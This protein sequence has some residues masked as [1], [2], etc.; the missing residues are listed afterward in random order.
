MSK[1]ALLGV[2]SVRNWL[3]ASLVALTFGCATEPEPPVKCEATGCNDGNP[4]T[5][6]ECAPLTGCKHQPQDGGACNDGDVCTTG[7]VCKASACAATAVLACT[8]DNV[9]TKDACDPAKGCTFTPIG[10]SCDDGNACSEGDACKAGSCVS[11]APKLCNDG[12]PCTA[13]GCDAGKCTTSA[14]VGAVCDDGD[15]CTKA[16]ACGDKGCAGTAIACVDSNPCT[17]ESCDK[18]SGCKV[19]V[20]TEPCD[21]GSKCTKA[22]ICN[23]GACKGTTV[24]CS[25]GIV[26]TIDTCDSTT[27]CQMAAVATLCSDDN[28]CTADACDPKVGCKHSFV[29]KQCDDGS[30]CTS[31]DQCAKG[32]CLGVPVGCD[33]DN[34]CTSDACLPSEGCKSSEVPDGKLCN[35][36]NPCT[37]ND[38]CKQGTCKG[39]FTSCDDS[40]ACT[41][42]EC[43]PKSGCVYKPIAAQACDDFNAC[44][45]GD[46][47]NGGKC[48]A[49]SKDKECDDGNPCTVDGCAPSKGCLHT[50][51]E[52][53]PCSDGNVCTTGDKCSA[54]GKCGGGAQES[55]NDDN[56]CTDDPCD[57]KAGC[58]HLP[59][60][61][62]C[63]DGN[64]CTSK[65]KCDEG[66]CGGGEPFTCD[67]GNVC[68]AEACVSKPGETG[69]C[70]F[71]P[72]ANVEC[73]DGNAC[74]INDI[75]GATG[76]CVGMQL[77]ECSDKSVCTSDFCDPKKGCV[78]LWLEGEYC[79]DFNACTVNEVCSTP[80]TCDSGQKVNCDDF[81]AC[82][83]D[84]CNKIVGCLHTPLDSG[85]VC[86]DGVSCTPLSYC[87]AGKCAVG[88]YLKCND[89]NPCTV[90]G[91]DLVNGNCKY[92]YM[93]GLSCDDG[94]SCTVG[95]KCTLSGCKG[96]GKDCGDGN[97]CTTDSCANNI[98]VSKKFDCADGNQCTADSCDVVSGCQ[99][100]FV[101]GKC[102]DSN[103]CTTVDLCSGGICGGLQATNCND[104]N[105][106][107]LDGCDSKS[108]CTHKDLTGTACL[109]N[110]ACTVNEKCAAGVCK[111]TEKV[112]NDG[113]DCTVDFCDILKGCQAANKQQWTPCFDD[114][115]KSACDGAGMCSFLPFTAGF[116]PVPAGTAAVGCNKAQDAN[117]PADASPAHLVKMPPFWLDVIEVTN[118]K[119]RQCIQA[120]GCKSKPAS[121]AGC[122]Y[123]SGS[124][125]TYDLRPVN[126][127]TSQQAAEYCKWAGKRLPT[128]HEWEMAARGAC[129]QGK[130][131][132][133][134]AA[135]PKY[136]WGNAGPTCGLANFNEYGYFGCGEGLPWKVGKGKAGPYGHADLIGNV[137]EFTSD[138]Y[139]SLWYPKLSGTANGEPQTNP[140]N[141][142]VWWVNRM[143]RG[144]G[145]DSPA[146]DLRAYVRKSWQ[147]ESTHP[148]IGFRCAQSPK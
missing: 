93:D 23:D 83:D 19:T 28:S 65:E 36:A 43:D 123:T 60:T 139:D 4:C 95:D 120:G 110:N 57:S 126:C 47:C 46:E 50:V 136:P 30:L 112:C 32:F 31:G 79:N 29:D 2:A 45:V 91:C 81:N 130:D 37:A 76:N 75:C 128:E 127:V 87:E 89:A 146:Q 20:N 129:E 97:A 85:T 68:T 18:K 5:K 58:K 21:D 51:L 72:K 104:G 98:C 27:G 84:S 122:T 54:E 114:S 144:G 69:K 52:D 24:D 92:T 22:D 125:A 33:D 63:D 16:D 86:D 10:G 8:D 94:N 34:A 147:A 12:D 106:C 62:L 64:A 115:L 117:C 90:D 121:G 53:K 55:C 131:S 101:V 1:L 119:F 3:A 13:D 138:Q 142:Y 134:I 88:E 107:T 59:K 17:S 6:D 25:D 111:T 133:C 143:I 148:A 67:D 118:F 70:E 80:Q 49:G 71:A 116:L 73:N 78:N 96:N 124:D 7:D 15:A 61:G 102:D 103:A 140:E 11:G 14:A 77:K 105:P 44:T 9:C 56:P 66:K 141:S 26:C 135:T 40:N 35:D 145:Y 137:W 48:N 132:S 74:T 99:F 109:D 100:T 42:D 41:T 39:S 113:N 38:Q 82:T 108:G